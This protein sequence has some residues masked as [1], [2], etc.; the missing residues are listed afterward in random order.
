[1]DCITTNS[2]ILTLHTPITPH[3]T[4]QHNHSAQLNY[5]TDTHVAPF[6]TSIVHA[7]SPTKI[8]EQLHLVHAVLRCGDNTNAWPTISRALKSDHNR[9][10]Q[11]F[12]PKVPFPHLPLPPCLTTFNCRVVM[13]SITKLL[14]AIC[15]MIPKIQFI[16]SITII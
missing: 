15:G 4:T 12:L 11:F 1:M 8:A 7:L 9:D 2:S 3:H 6:N 14:R 16:Y 5:T 13:P 10:R